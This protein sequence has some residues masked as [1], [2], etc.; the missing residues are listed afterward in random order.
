MANLRMI[1]KKLQTAIL[2]TKTSDRYSVH[3][4]YR[5]N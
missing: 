4:A 2:S 3:W 1:S 5:K